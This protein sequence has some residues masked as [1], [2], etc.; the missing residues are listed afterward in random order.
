MGERRHNEE[1][2]TGSWKSPHR[3]LRLGRE[4]KSL[5]PPLPKRRGGRRE[6]GGE[7]EI[8]GERGGIP[9]RTEHRCANNQQEDNITHSW[10]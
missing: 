3:T 9:P 8:G 1:G 10:K 7:W 2:S 4:K 6:R 5:P